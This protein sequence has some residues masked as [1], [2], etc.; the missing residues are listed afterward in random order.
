MY[1]LEK[2]I[3]PG[4]GANCYLFWCEETMKGIVIDPG[5]GAKM[6]LNKIRSLKLEIIMIVLTHGHSDHLGALKEIREFLQ[7][8]VAMHQ[9]DIEI[10]DEPML[11]K[12]LI[13]NPPEIFLTEDQELAIGNVVLKVIHTPGHTPGGICLYTDNI[14]FSGDTLFQNAVGR[15]D[16]PGGNFKQILSSIRGKI[17]VL[18]DETRVYPGHEESTSIGWEKEN[19]PF[20]N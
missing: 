19:N 1:N 18:P 2:I 17:F 11:Q 16:F 4:M 9:A 20:F 5:D 3:T 7:V 13:D 15:T 8:P 6:I 12:E 10:I 14:L